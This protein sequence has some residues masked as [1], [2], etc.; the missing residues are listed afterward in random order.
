[1]LAVR[2]RCSRASLLRHFE[3]AKQTRLLRLRSGAARGDEPARVARRHDLLIELHL[4]ADQLFWLPAKRQQSRNNCVEMA[5]VRCR[6]LLA[7]A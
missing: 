3:R 5:G 7:I 4:N 1:M 6:H 2:W